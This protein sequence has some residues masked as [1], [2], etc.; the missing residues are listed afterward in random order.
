MATGVDANIRAILNVI[1][2]QNERHELA[3]SN[4]HKLIHV[5]NRE[6]IREIELL[7]RNLAEIRVEVQSNS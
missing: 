5:E 4:L 2:K 7:G 6:R 1:Q 3:L